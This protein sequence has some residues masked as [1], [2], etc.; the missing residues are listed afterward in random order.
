MSWSIFH[1]FFFSFWGQLKQHRNN[2]F[3]EDLKDLDSKW[4]TEPFMGDYYLA[5]F[6]MFCMIVALFRFSPTYLINFGDVPFTFYF[7]KN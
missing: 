5:G 6:L 1:H 4:G 7:I 2:L 3:L